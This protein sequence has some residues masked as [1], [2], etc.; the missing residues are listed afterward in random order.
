MLL[1]VFFTR[2]SVRSVFPMD[3]TF[4]YDLNQVFLPS[5]LASSSLLLFAGSISCDF[6]T[7]VW[8]KKPKKKL[9]VHWGAILWAKT[10]SI[11]LESECWCLMWRRGIIVQCRRDSYSSNINKA[12]HIMVLHWYFMVVALTVFHAEAEIAD[13]CW[14]TD[15]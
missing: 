8:K 2:I 13:K 4:P 11:V 15:S 12:E 6:L 9:F 1:L 7:T 14:P 10:Y 5:V 3:Y